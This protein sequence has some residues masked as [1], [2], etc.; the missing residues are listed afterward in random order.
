[1]LRIITWA[2]FAVLALNASVI[3]AT[4]ACAML[5]P[6]VAEM[7]VATSAEMPCHGA[8]AASHT[9][10]ADCC[11]NGV[12]MVCIQAVLHMASSMRDDMPRLIVATTV[13]YMPQKT[14]WHS[15]PP[16]RPPRMA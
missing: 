15:L 11:K 1:M 16:M 12:C 2:I 10:K 14:I 6:S 13:Q 8:M 9:T 4:Y 7:Q 3:P 5:Q